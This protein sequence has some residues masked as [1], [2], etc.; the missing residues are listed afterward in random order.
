MHAQYE[1][2]RIVQPT[3]DQM[4]QRT[5]IVDQITVDQ[6][7][8][9]QMSFGQ[10]TCYPP[11]PF[12]RQFRNLSDVIFTLCMLATARRSLVKSSRALGDPGTM[13]TLIVI[14]FNMGNL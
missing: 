14:E 7:C 6:N 3:V 1:N 2:R 4:L 10:M 8:V 9:D 12:L 13:E 11:N 5:R